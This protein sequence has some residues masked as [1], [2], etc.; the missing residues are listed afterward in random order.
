MRVLLDTS[1]YSAFRRGHPEAVEALRIASFIG[2]TAV[3]LGELL[4]GFVLGH[5]E[6]RNRQE[7]REFLASPRVHILPMGLE[8]GERFAVIYRLLRELG[9][10]V[11][12]NDLWIAA[13]AME[14]GLRIITADEHYRAIPMILTEFLEGR[15]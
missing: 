4:S 10:P 2:L 6:A 12:T 15:A 7:L 8:T 9:R 14:H 11:P 13:S 1:A 3:V 5:R